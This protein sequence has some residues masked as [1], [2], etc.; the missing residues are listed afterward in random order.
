M[1]LKSCLCYRG[2]R[3]T[4]WSAH[5]TRCTQGWVVALTVRL[6]SVATASLKTIY[7]A[8]GYDYKNKLFHTIQQYDNNG[9]FHEKICLKHMSYWRFLVVQPS[10][11][12]WQQFTQERGW[13]MLRSWQTKLSIKNDAHFLPCRYTVDSVCVCVCAGC[14]ELK[15]PKKGKSQSQTL[16]LP[17]TRGTAV[18][19]LLLSASS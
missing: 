15:K 7:I 10:S 19:A 12:G 5:L 18:S 17:V 1:I 4:F 8:T 14:A 13:N 3:F 9:K 6:E 11:W 16:T 2:G